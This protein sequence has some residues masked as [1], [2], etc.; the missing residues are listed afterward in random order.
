MTAGPVNIHATTIVIGTIGL[1][2][3]GDSGSGKSMMAFACLA[4]ARREAQFAALVADDRTLISQFG[5]QVMA[6]QPPSIAGL[7][8]LRGSGIASVEQTMASLVHYAV[9][10]VKHADTQRLPPEGE[11][12]ALPGGGVLPLL[13]IDVG[14]PDP[15]AILTALIPNLLTAER[16]Q[17]R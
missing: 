17:W 1:L 6:E 2:F 11:T 8:E 4:A 3:V 7:I 12:Y 14:A 15:L 9:R 13:R 16:S 5:K 10:P